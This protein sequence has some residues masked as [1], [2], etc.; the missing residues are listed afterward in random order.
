MRILAILAPSHLVL[1]DGLDALSLLQVGHTNSD[2]RLSGEGVVRHYKALRGTRQAMSSTA[3]TDD[4]ILANVSLLTICES[5]DVIRGSPSTWLG[6]MGGFNQMLLNR[7]PNSL[8]SR[9]S[10]LVFYQ[11]R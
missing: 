8:Q 10:M 5:F 2:Q 3:A 9:L 1:Q 7:G 6:H 4:A 11:S